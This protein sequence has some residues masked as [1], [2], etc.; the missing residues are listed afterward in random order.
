M[1]IMRWGTDKRW[2][3]ESW[4]DT[5]TIE[6]QTVIDEKV[7]VIEIKT[8]ILLWYYFCGVSATKHQMWENREKIIFIIS[9]KKRKL[10]HWFIIQNFWYWFQKIIPL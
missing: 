8:K 6:Y 9:R 7:G 4:K 3:C 2:L 10:P 5:T 1:R